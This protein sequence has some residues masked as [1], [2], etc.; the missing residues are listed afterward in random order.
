M[1]TGI[2]AKKLGMTRIFGEDGSHIPVTLLKAEG[3]QVV[4]VKTTEKDGYNSV[5][6]G[7]GVK[8]VKNVT[9]PLKGFYAKK[10]IEPKQTLVEFRVSEDALLNEGDTISVNH[11]VVGQKVDVAGVSTGKGFAGAMKRHNFAGLEAT[12]GVSISHRSHGSTGHC[13]EPGRVFKGKKMAGQYGNKRISQQNLEVAFI[14]EEAGIVALKGAVPGSEDTIIEIKDAVKAKPFEGLPFPA[15]LVGSAKESPKEEVKQ[16]A[17]A[18]AVEE[19]NNEN[20][21]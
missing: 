6:L 10:K 3:N 21:E 18:P 19:T 14:D 15:S 16:E 9:K 1:R 7:F 4:T 11:F 13:Q 17:E 12:H 2:I 5:Q 20:K 8:K